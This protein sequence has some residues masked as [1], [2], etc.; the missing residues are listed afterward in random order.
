MT[1]G[2]SPFHLARIALE[3]EVFEAFGTAELEHLAVIADKGITVS[4]ENI[5]GAEVTLL[6]PH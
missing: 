5:A 2:F 4:W 1:V 3:L 6:Y